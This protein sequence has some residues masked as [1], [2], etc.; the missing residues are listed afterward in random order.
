MPYTIKRFIPL[1]L[2]QIEEFRAM[3]SSYSEIVN[4]WLP[5]WRRLSLDEKWLYYKV[6][7]SGEFLMQA[8]SWEALREFDFIQRLNLEF[9]KTNFS[10]ADIHYLDNLKPEEHIDLAC[11]CFVN[12]MPPGGRDADWKHYNNFF[13]SSLAENNANNLV[14]VVNRKLREKV[15]ENPELLFSINDTDFEQFIGG[16]FRDEGYIVELTKKTRDGGY[17]IIA[18]SNNLIP[19][20][21][22]IECKRK[23][24][25]KASIGIEIIR[26]VIGAY[27]MSNIG[28][29]KIVLV[30]PNQYA[31]GAKETA[32][33]SILRIE[34]R[35]YEDIIAWV[36][37]PF[38]K[39]K[40]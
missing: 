8:F 21:L 16:I 35:D 28:A 38:E 39:S 17:D 4:K 24:N 1:N 30:T 31:R 19:Q 25:R 2:E 33:T 5:F 7:E 29:D 9:I 14:L 23:R 13:D 12:S 20:K 11:Q 32:G 34:L 26:E 18:V 40:P 27:S 37:R 6:F 15:R 36:T 22:L 10:A 3:P